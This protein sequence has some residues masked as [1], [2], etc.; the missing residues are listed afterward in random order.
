TT[1][2]SAHFVSVGDAA[3][4]QKKKSIMQPFWIGA[5]ASID[6]LK[7]ILWTVTCWR[8]ATDWGF[9]RIR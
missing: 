8:I 9:R 3:L 6:G 2:D 5:P 4:R 1:T 7:Q